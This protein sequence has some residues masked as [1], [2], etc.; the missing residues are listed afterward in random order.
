MMIKK[1]T[2]I[3]TINQ[4]CTS[5]R[6]LVKFSDKTLTCIIKCKQ[7][8][9]NTNKLSLLLTQKAAYTWSKTM[10]FHAYK[11]VFN[12]N[13]NNNNNSCYYYYYYYYYYYMQ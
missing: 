12:N 13:N 4:F 9:F 3:I 11:V 6:S 5:A 8:N 1:A 7:I 2:V 10:Y